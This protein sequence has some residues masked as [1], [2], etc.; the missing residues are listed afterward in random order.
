VVLG[1]DPEGDRALSRVPAKVAEGRWLAAPG[2][3]VLGYRLAQRLDLKVGE[4]LV[5]ETRP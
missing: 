4:R 5:V 1:V 3:V 2:E